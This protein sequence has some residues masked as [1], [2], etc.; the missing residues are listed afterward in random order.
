VFT[1]ILNWYV[2]ADTGV[3]VAIGIHIQ[4]VSPFDPLPLP[5]QTTMTMYIRH[6]GDAIP[7]QVL[8]FGEVIKDEG[9]IF[10]Q[11]DSSLFFGCN[12]PVNYPDLLQVDIRSLRARIMTTIHEHRKAYS[13]K[14]EDHRRRK[15]VRWEADV[16]V[17]VVQVIEEFTLGSSDKL[18][19]KSSRNQPHLLTSEIA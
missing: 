17:A 18:E 11:I 14:T 10:A 4:Y 7:E 16:V 15:R 2:T 3:G 9:P 6:R 13:A 12:P 1:E 8:S 5:E 19:G